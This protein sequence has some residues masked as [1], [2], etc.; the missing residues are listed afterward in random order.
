MGEKRVK[1]ETF[2]VNYFCDN[3]DT[4]IKTSGLVFATSPP[5]HEH[6]CPNCGRI[7]EFRGKSYPTQVLHYNE[8]GY[9]EDIVGELNNIKKVVNSEGMDMPVEYTRGY[10]SAMKVINVTIEKR[11][12]EL[13]KI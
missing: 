1:V 2:L 4:V 7:Y 3:C 12:K 6:K 11:I 9:E 13:E 8:D 10:D 5:I